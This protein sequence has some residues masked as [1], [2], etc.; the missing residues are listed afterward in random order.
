M[1]KES[2]LQL[3]NLEATGRVR[4]EEER[5]YSNRRIPQGQPLNQKMKRNSVLQQVDG[6]LMPEITIDTEYSASELFELGKNFQK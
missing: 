3:K 1:T 2:F 5:S 6:S 4:S